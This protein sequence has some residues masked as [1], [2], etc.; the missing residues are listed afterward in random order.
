MEEAQRGAF[1]PSGKNKKL[2]ELALNISRCN[3]VDQ[4]L[5]LLEILKEISDRIDR[6][7][8][9]GSD[10]GSVKIQS[11]SRLERVISFLNKNY[12]RNI[13]LEETSSYAAMNP[14]AFCHFFKSVSSKSFKN[15]LLDMRISYACKL[16][17][18]GDM[19]ISRVSAEC[20][21]ESISYF[22][23]MFKKSVGYV[24]T[25]YKKMMLGE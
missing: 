12:T 10:F 11:S 3:D 15:Y 5:R 24:P 13:T 20:S 16:L 9:S 7:S 22:N 17:T 1:F 6:E 19:E 21:F 18:I 23:R 14:T 25:Y 4:I 2:W 8:I